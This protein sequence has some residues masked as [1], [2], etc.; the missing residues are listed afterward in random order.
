MLC[1][2]PK[3][4]VALCDLLMSEGLVQSLR[5]TALALRRCGHQAAFYLAAAVSDFYIP[6]HDMVSL[7][8]CHRV[9]RCSSCS[10]GSGAFKAGL[11]CCRR[12]TKSNL[13]LWVTG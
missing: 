7:A 1:K 6:W 11:K 9:S 5:A 12:S 2:P 13:P 8:H 3:T 10:C 4:A